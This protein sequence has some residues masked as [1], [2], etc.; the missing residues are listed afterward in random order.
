MVAVQQ[1]LYVDL[2]LVEKKPYLL[3]IS[4]PMDYVTANLVENKSAAVLA[5]A[6]RKVLAEYKAR[7][8]TV[9]SV[10]I[11][12]ESAAAAFAQ[13]IQEMGSLVDQRKD[14]V[15]VIERTAQTVKSMVRKLKFGLPFALFG[16]MLAFCVMYAVQRLNLFVRLSSGVLQA[17]CDRRSQEVR[18]PIRQHSTRRSPACHRGQ[19]EYFISIH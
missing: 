15:E 13:L 10:F 18:L 9:P 1:S 8:F 11:D 19:V 16:L 7:R 5:K 14:H 12:G 2:M 3:T 4:K 6:L 17:E